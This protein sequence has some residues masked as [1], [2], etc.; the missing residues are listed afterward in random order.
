[1][2][3]IKGNN[4]TIKDNVI[5][6]ENV[7]L[8]DDVYIDYGVIIRDNVTI[9]KG[10]FI[11]AKSIIGEYVADFFKDRVNKVHPLV[12]GE[13]SLI[14]SEAIIYGGSIIG[15]N[16]QTG[17]RVTIRENSKIG[18][19]VRIGTLTDVQGDC[20][21]GNYVSIHSKVFIGE[22]T[23]I[24]DYVWIFP[25]VV[26]TNDPNP[27]SNTLMGIVIEEFVSVSAGAMILPGVTIKKD[28]LIGAGSIV[29]RN[30]G[31]GKIA[32]GNPAREVGPVT[33]IKDKKTGQQVYPWRYTFDRGMPWQG[34]GYDNW[35]NS[36]K[37]I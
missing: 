2:N 7:I 1:M 13:N 34:I 31:E 36:L 3:I 12:I 32:L 14:R 9:K 21:I 15:N 33:R 4:V 23:I 37:E 24:K 29:N 19:H 20:H 26:L 35:V 17:H 27:P 11:G 10:S 25:H 28:A 6:G 16:F 8:E 30:V 18:H 22:K 5:I